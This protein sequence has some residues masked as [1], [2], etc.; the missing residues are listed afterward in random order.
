MF[1]REFYGSGKYASLAPSGWEKNAAV[2]DAH[3]VSQ[4][5]ALNFYPG[6]IPKEGVPYYPADE[7]ESALKAAKYTAA[8]L[9]LKN[10]TKDKSDPTCNV[11]A[12]WSQFSKSSICTEVGHGDPDSTW[13]EVGLN[14]KWPGWKAV[15]SFNYSSGKFH[16]VVKNCSQTPNIIVYNKDIPSSDMAPAIFT[17]ISCYTG[18][19]SDGTNQTAV[20][21]SG[22]TH[23]GFVAF[24]GP[25]EYQTK[26]F[27]EFVPQ[28]VGSMQGKLFVDKIATK[29]I[30]IGTAFAEAKWEAWQYWKN[31]GHA[32]DRDAQ[33]Y[34]LYGDPALEPYKPNMPYKS[35]SAFDVSVDFGE[36]KTGSD[37]SVKVTA[38]DLVTGS[39]V[40]GA[41]VT[42][43][44]NGKT[45]NT[46]DSSITP[47]KTEGAYPMEIM[48]AKA[49][50]ATVTLK[51]TTQV[52]KGLTDITTL[53]I[54]VVIILFVVVIA[55]IAMRKKPGAGDDEGAESEE[56]DD[57]EEAGEE[58]KEPKEED[59][60]DKEK[61]RED[62]KDKNKKPKGPKV[63][64]ED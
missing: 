19:I 2:L 46:A 59:E 50:Y 42:V 8:S 51:Y 44:Y 7:W 36:I 34:L 20:I 55:A 57:I 33:M 38:K 60:E 58:G 54:F 24:I 31:K 16:L 39:A 62:G 29:N 32:D 45:Y 49:G 37:F 15:V 26:C 64:G 48:V 25:A 53:L 40:S 9:W 22:F 11:N 17:M 43:K 12:I 6:Y 47:P 35:E 27:W 3:N 52:E 18:E 1:Y 63:L 28:G 13:L 41:T 61:E 4:P 14:G 21:S 10:W 5:E 56:E 30:A 23:A